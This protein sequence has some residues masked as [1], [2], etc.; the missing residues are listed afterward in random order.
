MTILYGEAGNGKA[1]IAEQAAHELADKAG[2]RLVVC[3][4]PRP[5]R[6]G[7]GVA[8]VFPLAPPTTDAGSGDIGALP[9]ADTVLPETA[10]LPVLS[11][12]TPDDG[13]LTQAASVAEAL[14]ERFGGVPVI[15]VAPDIDAYSPHD[16]HVLGQLVRS[17][18]YRVIA[19]ARQLSS[20]IEHIGGGPH[21]RRIGVGPLD[22]DESGGMLCALL[23]VDRIEP[24]TL[25]R[26]H[27]ASQGNGYA[28][29]VLAIGADREGRV[30]RS[31]GTAW[32]VGRDAAVTGEYAQLLAATCSP[33]EWRALEFIAQA[34][35]VTETALLRSFETAVFASLFERALIVPQARGSVQAITI[36]HPLLAA[37]LRSSMSPMRRIEL[38]D[39]IFSLLHAD[40]GDR[41]PTLDTERLLRLVMFGIAAGRRLPL[42]WLWSAFE[43]MSH[44]GD[45]HV[46]LRLAREVSGHPDATGAQAGTA[47]LRAARLSRLLGDHASRRAAL[48]RVGELLADPTRS[49]EIPLTLRIGLE[50]KLVRE[51]V[52]DGGD[53]DASLRTLDDIE[54]RTDD[55][56]GLEMVRSARV[57]ALAYAGRLREAADACPPLELS[58]DMRIEW[59]RSP[60]RAFAT[61]VLE[62]RGA[63]HDAVSNAEY[64]RLLSRLGPR[65][66]ADLIDVQGFCWLLGYWVSGSRES[67]RRVY[68]DLAR[69]ASA[70]V[71][72]EA[73]YSGLL[74]SGAV[75]LAVQE[76]RWAEAALS[77]ERLVD[78][79]EVSDPYT[80]APLVYAALALA[81]AVMGER[82]EALKALAASE[83]PGRGIAMALSGH[84]RVLAL[85]AR[86]WLHDPSVIEEASD[87][88]AW[89]AEQDLPLI[90][91]MALHLR[92][93][94]QGAVAAAD[95]A[96]A[97]E[98]SGHIDE[99]VSAAFLGHLERLRAGVGAEPRV[100]DEPEIRLLADLG[101]WLPLPR[102]SGLTPREREIVLLAALGH[103]SRFIAARLGISA[104]TVET[105]LS[106]AFGKIGVENRE[107][108]HDWVTRNRA[109]G[110]RPAV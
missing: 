23:G 29:A 58:D 95:L 105:H 55:A 108:L 39:S 75:L 85:R 25:R 20:A 76:G 19:T 51:E 93:V 71:H 44:G 77:A 14:D 107:E 82:D 96:R 31:R 27:H 104:R 68:D 79:L 70:E 28:L 24:A 16:L 10:S 3:A 100:T 84:R 33:E 67:A 69:E 13:F 63:L 26:W 86:Q 78:H 57:Q 47:A 61:L 101:V 106:H 87:L 22:L 40:Q 34:E 94:E 81:S 88:A 43:A 91:L 52:R 18:R 59:A 37:S 66:R 83:S 73:N 103:T 89:A 35:P 74:E 80:L 72:A 7:S 65:A 90:E 42:R 53:I 48:A 36:A 98:L 9:V 15:L 12:Q 4:F 30:R 41:D 1:Y 45:P 6:A 50:L 11:P 60:G 102:G 38:D 32:E 21:V 2:S 5:P 62:Q 64:A 46:M 49:E 97:R 110:D 54:A 8:S 92:A 109:V 56:A 17:G 99:A